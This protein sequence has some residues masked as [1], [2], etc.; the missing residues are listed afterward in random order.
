MRLNLL[1]R[2]QP[3]IGLLLAASGWALSHQVGSNNAFDSCPTGGLVAVIAS[4][5]GLLITGAGGY[6][7]LLG[8]RQGEGSGRSFLAAVGMLLAVIAAFAILL[9]VAAGL[10]LPQC[11]A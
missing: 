7:S 10:I 9:Q 1:E 6:Y 2:P 4:V 11:A 5:V 3:L 8:W